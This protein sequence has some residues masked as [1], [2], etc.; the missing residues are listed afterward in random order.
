VTNA[1]ANALLELA[2]KAKGHPVPKMTDHECVWIDCEFRT[3]IP[4]LCRD[5]LAAREA[6]R[7]IKCPKDTNGAGDCGMPACPY[8]GLGYNAALGDEVK[9]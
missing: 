5:L 4:A 1:E 6:L 7:R 9:P 2:E 8:C 3:A